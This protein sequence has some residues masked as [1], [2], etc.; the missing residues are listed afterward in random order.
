MYFTFKIKFSEIVVQITIKTNTPPDDELLV[1]NSALFNDTVTDS[2]FT[3]IITHRSKKKFR[4]KVCVI[5]PVMV[6]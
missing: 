2:K 3:S 1:Q 5:F 4:K 6:I